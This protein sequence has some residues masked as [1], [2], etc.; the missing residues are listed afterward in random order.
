[1]QGQLAAGIHQQLGLRQFI[2]HHLLCH[3][4]CVDVRSVRPED[5]D[6]PGQRRARSHA[7]GEGGFEADRGLRVLCN[8]SQEV[9]PEVH[10]SKEQ[11]VFEQQRFLL[12]V[13]ELFAH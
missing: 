3:D 2:V 6:Q 9:A 7:Q 1:M 10:Q 12:R 13:Q 11:C 8:L 5:Y 4:T